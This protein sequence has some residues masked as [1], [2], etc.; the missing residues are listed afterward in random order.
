MQDLL[1]AHRTD[2]CFGECDHRNNLALA[3]NEFQFEGFSVL[4]A[5]IQRASITPF[6]ATSFEIPCED[7][8]IELMDHIAQPL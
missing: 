5:M 1:T 4:V 7:H 2:I 6:E 3:G 8:S